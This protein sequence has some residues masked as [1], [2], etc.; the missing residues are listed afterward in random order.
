MESGLTGKQFVPLTPQSNDRFVCSKCG[1]TLF[2]AA[3]QFDAGCGFPSFWQHKDA[4]VKQKLLLT[5]GRKRI[6]LLCA[7]CGQHLGHLF[8]NKQTPTGVRYCINGQS[9]TRKEA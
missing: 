1:T 9:I 4:N 7:A 5:Y 6:Q 2:D 3:F 8:E